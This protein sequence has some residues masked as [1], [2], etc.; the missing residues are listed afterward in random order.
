MGGVGPE[1]GME[2]N[3]LGAIRGGD[4]ARDVGWRFRMVL[5][6]RGVSACKALCGLGMRR[7]DHLAFRAG[8]R[9]GLWL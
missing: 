2:S 6:G 5:K 7:C 9:L 3:D 1:M 8:S 4:L